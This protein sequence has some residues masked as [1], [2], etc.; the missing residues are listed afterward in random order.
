MK[1]ELLLLLPLLFVGLVMLFNPLFTRPGIFF[2]ATVDPAFPETADGRQVL[3][4]YRL[5]VVLWTALAMGLLF[6]L[7]TLHPVALLLPMLVVVGG[8]G[9]SYWLK[10]REVHEHFGVRAAEIRG[11]ELSKQPSHA[12]F[13]LALCLPPFLAIGAAALYLQAHWGQIPEAFPVHWG[14]DGQPNGWSHR[15]WHG[16][17]GPLLLCTALNLFLLGL[18]WLFTHASRRTVMRFVTVRFTQYMLYPLTF[19]I[20]LVALLPVVSTPLWLGPLVMLVSI[21]AIMVWGYR[22]LRA[23][24]GDAVPEP[25]SDSYWKAG[26]FYYNPNDP[27][28]FV[29]KRVG[30]GYTVNFANKISWLVMVGLLLVALLPALLLRR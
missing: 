14:A 7:P 12:N 29:S 18:G 1:L 26:M 22:Q 3:R 13:I 28:I 8:G 25:Q 27:A 23:P 20:L 10:F 9:F 19:T 2:G 17:F 5:Q 24:A 4:S 21:G 16:V 15:T 11:A 30:I 6:L